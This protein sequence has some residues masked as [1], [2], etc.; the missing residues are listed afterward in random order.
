MILKINHQHRCECTDIDRQ[1]MQY[2]SKKKYA[3]QGI[4]KPIL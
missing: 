2:T 1:A 4:I 3:M